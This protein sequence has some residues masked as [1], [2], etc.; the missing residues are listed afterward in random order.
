MLRS[1][2]RCF[3]CLRQNHISRNCRSSSRCA[4][5]N[6]RH[7]TSLHAS[8]PVCDA[9]QPNSVPTLE[10]RAILDTGSQR[11]YV[12]TRVKEAIRA[13]KSHSES[14]VIK[15][16][17]SECGE[18]RVCEIIQLRVATNDG[19][20]LVLPV[21]VVPHICNPVRTCSIYTSSG[22]YE[23]LSGL[24]LADPGVDGSDLETDL[25]IGS[26][27][28]WKVVTGR[29]VRGNN[30]PTAI[31]TRLGWVLSGPAEELQEDTVINFASTHSSHLLR[32]NSDAEVKDLDAGLKRFWDLESHGILKEE[33][34][35]RQQFSQQIT[36]NQGRYEVHLPWK[37]SHPHLP[38]SYDLCKRRLGGLLKRLSQNPEQL[39]HYDSIIQEQLQQGVVEIVREPAKYKSGRLHYLP[40][41]GVF[42]HDKQTTKLRVVYDASLNNCLHTGPNFGQNILDI[43]LQF[44]LHRIALLGDVEKAFLMVSVA[45]CDRDALRFLWVS[46]V[47]QPQHEIIVMRFTRV[48]FGVSA[49]PFLLNA[50]IDHHMSKLELTDRHFVDK[51]RRSIYVDDVATGSADVD[52][53]YEFYV[54][55]KMH[56]AQASFNLR[57]FESNSPELCRRI[58]ENERE[59]CKELHKD[60]WSSSTHSSNLTQEPP[61]RQVLGINWDVFND[62]LLFDIGDVAQQMKEARPTKRNAVSLVTRFYDPL[63]I[64][65]PIT[66][67]FKQLFQKLCEKKLDWDENLTGGLLTEWESLTSDLQQFTPIRIPRCSVQPLE[68]DSATTYE[69][70]LPY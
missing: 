10:V 2:G 59:L 19:G 55:A 6:G 9:T 21:V 23:H 31:E 68:C 33:H 24:E 8:P 60:Q 13:R 27:H 57:K 4:E 7:H 25:L 61:L 41:H 18:K 67:R 42:R 65:S 22:A 14:M 47:N 29:V 37:Q 66:V 70:H 5:C 28:Y 52:T 56:L 62:Q 11:S 16:F 58:Q 45:E 34:H 12:T 17:G 30:G 54:R 26:D 32:V 1:S 15:T 43:L 64:I 35:V 48:V 49:S 3:I 36:F 69:C 44:R 63:G 40:H 50:T 20:S 46:D 53:A 51:F 38:D 39:R